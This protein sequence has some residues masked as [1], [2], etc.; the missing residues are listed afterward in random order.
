MGTPT[1]QP[2]TC[3]PYSNL[4]LGL[5][6]CSFHFLSHSLVDIQLY[7]SFKTLKKMWCLTGLRLLILMEFHIIII[8]VGL[9]PLPVAM[10]LP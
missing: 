4:V 2:L 9:W 1:D 7:A 8:N 6:H 10:L 3:H 5:S